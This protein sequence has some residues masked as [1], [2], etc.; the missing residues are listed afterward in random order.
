MVAKNGGTSRSGYGVCFV[1]GVAAAAPTSAK[2]AGKLAP[3]LGLDALLSDRDRDEWENVD[4]FD[5]FEAVECDETVETVEVTAIAAKATADT[6]HDAFRSAV[7][8]SLQKNDAASLA[9][10]DSPQSTVTRPDTFRSAVFDSLQKNNAAF[11]SL[12]ST[13]LS[14]GA[15]LVPGVEFPPLSGMEKSAKPEA[16]RVAI[17]ARDRDGATALM[18]AARAGRARLAALLID[19]GADTEAADDAGHT[20]LILAAQGGHTDVVRV[21]LTGV[22]DAPSP[23]TTDVEEEDAELAAALAQVEELERGA[24]ACAAPVAVPQGHWSCAHCTLVNS[25]ARRVC[26]ACLVAR[27]DAYHTSGDKVASSPWRG[28]R[29]ADLMQIQLGKPRHRTGA[30]AKRAPMIKRAALPSTGREVHI[31]HAD[32]TWSKRLL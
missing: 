16:A 20:A 19:Q 3:K 12:Q 2:A 7:F 14:D 10:F 5:D 6:R 28:A 15:V 11:D 23:N 18:H 9:A 22:L 29:E 4:D 24:P 17:D 27:T 25:C 26:D 30:W 21:L 8:D 1:N 32:G 13:A 31:A